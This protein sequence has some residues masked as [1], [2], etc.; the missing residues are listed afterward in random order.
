[1]IHRYKAIVLLLMAADLLCVRPLFLTNYFDMNI[2]CTR[3]CGLSGL[4]PDLLTRPLLLII[5]F[6]PCLRIWIHRFQ[7]FIFSQKLRPLHVIMMN[8]TR[9]HGDGSFGGPKIS[10]FRLV[11]CISSV[12]WWLGCKLI[13]PFFLMHLAEVSAAKYAKYYLHTANPM[14]GL[15]VALRIMRE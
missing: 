11:L 1:M 8:S 5:L 12:S 7:G 9:P 10:L 3:K 4:V 2:G 13:Y 14:S 15:I 6:L